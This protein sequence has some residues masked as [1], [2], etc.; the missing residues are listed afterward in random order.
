MITAHRAV[1]AAGMGMSMAIASIT[2]SGKC[3]WIVFTAI[4]RSVVLHSA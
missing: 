2:A 3:P 1:V 4:A